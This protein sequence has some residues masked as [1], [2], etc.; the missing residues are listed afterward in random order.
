MAVYAVRFDPTDLWGP[1]AEPG[2]VVY[3]E[4][5][6]AYLCPAAEADEKEES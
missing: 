1:R 5:Y 3:G 6:E 2:S 4:L